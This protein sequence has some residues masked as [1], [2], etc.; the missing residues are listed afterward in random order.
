MN[1]FSNGLDEL[2]GNGPNFRSNQVLQGESP[3]LDIPVE[4]KFYESYKDM[5]EEQA[6]EEVENSNIAYHSIDDYLGKITTDIDCELDLK[7][8]KYH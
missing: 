7:L 2:N 8:Y 4:Q 1:F 5:E 3:D 6:Q